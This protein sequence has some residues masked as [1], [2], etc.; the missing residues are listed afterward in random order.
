MKKPNATKLVF[1]SWMIT[2]IVYSATYSS[3]LVAFLTVEVE[4]PPFDS[5]ETLLTQ[6]NYKFGTLGQTFMKN[7]FKVRKRGETVANNE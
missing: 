5:L 1:I 4:K 3:N 2:C 7:L 6:Q